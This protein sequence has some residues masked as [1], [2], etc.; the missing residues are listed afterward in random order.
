VSVFLAWCGSRGILLGAGALAEYIE[1][2]RAGKTGAASLNLALYAGKAALMQAAEHAGMPGREL[3]VLKT[4]MDQIPAEQA[5]IPEIRVIAE[6]DRKRLLAGMPLRIRLISRFLY[7]TGARVSEALGVSRD[8]CKRDGE[9][10]LVRLHGKGRK[11][12]TVRI[13]IGLLCC[14]RLR[15]A[16]MGVV[17]PTMRKG[18]R[19]CSRQ[20]M[21]GAIRVSTSGGKW[22]EP[23]GVSLSA[24]WVRIRCA[25]QEPPTCTPRRRTLRASRSFSVMRIVQPRHATTCGPG[26]ATLISSKERTCRV[27]RSH[28][29]SC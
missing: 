15:A 6:D 5:G 9:R 12:R 26:S 29:R 1:V 27:W 8:D 23:R 24:A 14:T 13:P 3:A 11:E 28:M 4:A 19:F 21:E 17:D 22:R 20:K 10:V 16:F 25:T 18:I 7:A 2:L